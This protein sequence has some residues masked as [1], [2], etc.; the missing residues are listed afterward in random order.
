MDD[1]SWKRVGLAVVVGGTAAMV[2]GPVV[3]S[4]LG[5][6]AGG[7]AAGSVA[8]N[9]MSSAA[10]ANG[11]VIAAGSTISVLQSAGVLGFSVKSSALIAGVA[12]G[13]TALVTGVTKDSNNEKNVDDSI[14]D[15]TRSKSFTDGTSYIMTNATSI[16]Q[17]AG[18]LGSYIKPSFLTTKVAGDGRALDTGVTKDRN[19]EEILSVDVSRDP[20]LYGLELPKQEVTS[21]KKIEKI[22]MA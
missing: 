3:V 6:K 14:V 16:L 18:A 4:A 17:S 15:G 2:G 20:A 21:K 7:I 19:K 12:G 13:G 11:G 1:I 5:F 10:I 9:M 22:L 8:A